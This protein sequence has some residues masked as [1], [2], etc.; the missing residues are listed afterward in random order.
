M[1]LPDEK[2]RTKYKREKRRKEEKRREKKRKEEKRREKKRKEEK[3][4]EK[5]NQFL[6][7]L[8]VASFPFVFFLS[9]FLSFYLI[10]R[11]IKL[12]PMSNQQMKKFFQ[13]ILCFVVLVVGAVVAVGILAVDSGAVCVS[14]REVESELM[15]N[16]SSL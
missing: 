16:I 1:Y 11:T 6:I 9:F 2:R 5:K 14:G 10:I 12:N 8:L 4:R 15:G 7:F 3:R 13:K